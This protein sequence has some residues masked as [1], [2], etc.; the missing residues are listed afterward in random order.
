[1]NIQ[2]RYANIKANIV[3]NM[4]NF[5]ENVEKMGMC[6][7]EKAHKGGALFIEIQ[8]YGGMI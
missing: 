3:V 5:W 4:Q 7:R 2:K 6:A 1:M 8:R